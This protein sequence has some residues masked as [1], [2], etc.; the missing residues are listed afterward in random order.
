MVAAGSRERVRGHP[1]EIHEEGCMRTRRKRAKGRGRESTQAVLAVDVLRDEGE[2][3][4]G[5]RRGEGERWRG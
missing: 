2:G 3:K 4:V 1:K 5:E